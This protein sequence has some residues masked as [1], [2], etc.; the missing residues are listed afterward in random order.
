MVAL[1]QNKALIGDDGIS[2]GI[3]RM[4][5]AQEMS[6]YKRNLRLRYFQREE[7]MLLRKKDEQSG[8]NNGSLTS[9]T[10]SDDRDFNWKTIVKR[11]KFAKWIHRTAIFQ[12]FLDH[13]WNRQ[14][15]L[16]RPL[17][18]MLWLLMPSPHDKDAARNTESNKL[19]INPWIDRIA[20]LGL[21]CSSF[22]LFSGVANVP[23]LLTLWLCQ[24]SLMS[25]GGVF[26]GYGWEP[27]LAELM[28]HSMFIVPFIS[29]SITKAS[30]SPVSNVGV[31]TIRWF[32]FRI[33]MGAGL[34]KLKSG[35]SKWKLNNLTTMNYFYETQPI[36]NPLTKYFHRMPEKWH[37]FEVLTN[38]FVELVAPW[39]LL[40]P[41]FAVA[42]GL[43]QLI[44]QM[45]LITSGNLSFL[46]WLT[47]V[48]AIFCL[49]DAFLLSQTK[50]PSCL[51]SSSLFSKISLPN[52]AM[53]STNPSLIR[54]FVDFSF[55]SLII[56]L[57]IPV[58]R[59]LCR[60]KQLMNASFDPLRLVNSYG[61]FGTVSE[62]RMELVVKSAH[63][64]IYGQWKEYEFKAKPGNIHKRP[65][66]LSPYHHRLDWQMWISSLYPTIDNSS[67]MYSFLYK[68]LQQDKEVIG[69]IK[70]DPWAQDKKLRPKYIRVDK[71]RYKF[72]YNKTSIEEVAQEGEEHGYWSRE[73]VGKYF[74]RQGLASLDTLEDNIFLSKK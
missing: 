26:Y 28:F 37:K 4:E 63:D 16:G 54:K 59:N 21:L 29:L 17:I 55:A 1:R 30:S 39:L 58:V 36:P 3:D 6:R 12:Y 49:N 38:H 47:M 20:Y 35:D 61:A 53:I 22:L 42:G 23:I 14:D 10:I 33:M 45:V 11:T 15:R 27:Q 64:P 34:I 70:S 57:S 65:R 44:F 72:N 46:N 71:Y 40:I 48:P 51:F 9:Y 74:P 25:I 67:W 68:L 24:R 73:Y 43:I 60:K 56:I 5:A 7:E 69:L 31:W 66:F 18:S 62:E 41:R 2:P 19:K 50:I 8:Q 32:L 52:L 13:F